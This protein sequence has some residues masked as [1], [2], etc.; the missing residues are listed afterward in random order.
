MNCS[1]QSTCGGCPFRHKNLNEYRND[2]FSQIKKILSPLSQSLP[3]GKPV[4]IDDGTRRR[5]SLAFTYTHKKLIFGFN[6]KS[7]N[8]I[9]DINSCMLLTARLNAILPEIRKLLSEI[10]TIP[11]QIKK[12]KKI[13]HQNICKGDIWVCDTA[14]GID[15]TLEYDAPIE[16]EHRLIISDF[17]NNNSDVIRICHRRKNTD[18]PEPIVEK[19]KPFITISSFNVYIPS[20]TFLQP[21][22]EGEQALIDLVLE[23]AGNTRSKIFDLFCGVGTFSY[24]LSAKNPLAHIVAVDSSKELLQGFQESVNRNRI[25]NIETSERN[26]FK[27]P[28]TSEEFYDA[29]IVVFDPPRA[30]ASAQSQMLAAIPTDKKP[31]KVIA[32]SCNPLTF[33][34]DAKILLQ[35]GYKLEHINFVDQFIYSNHSELVAL[36]TKL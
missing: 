32:V 26:L 25:L 28:L 30:G 14:N 34:N 18:Y 2:K 15:I 22:K 8:V 31:Q 3:W 19:S 12:G 10:C 24:A 1:E 6:Q 20:G 21:S 9:I 7:S 16:L 13:I 36:F 11:Y 4:F 5:A 29:E 23:Y 33:V 27:Y 35:G 17:I